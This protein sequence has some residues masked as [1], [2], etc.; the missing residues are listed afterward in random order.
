MLSNKFQVRIFEKR[1]LMSSV[2]L[3]I[4]YCGRNGTEVEDA[5]TWLL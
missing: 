2:G 4:L 3:R 5:L 1:N